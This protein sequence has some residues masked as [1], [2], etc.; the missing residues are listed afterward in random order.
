MLKIDQI[1]Q[2]STRTYHF[3]TIDFKFQNTGTAAAFLWKF[4]VEVL[5]AEIDTMPVLGFDIG[6]KNKVL[7]ML[8]VNNGWGTAHDCQ[9]RISESILNQLYADSM[10]QYTGTIQSGEQKRILFFE[11]DLAN[12]GRFTTISKELLAIKDK[13]SW[14]SQL[15]EFT[16]ISENLV[17]RFPHRDATRE[18]IRGIRLGKAS[19]IW[20]FKDDKNIR[21]TGNTEIPY[22]MKESATAREF[23]LTEKGFYEFH[24]PLA[25]IVDS[26]TT[27]CT[28]I[29]PAKGSHELTYPISR[30]VPSGDV[31]RFHIMV[32][33][34]MSCHLSL[35][36]KFFIDQT[37]IVESEVFDINIW[38][39]RN[40]QWHSKYKDGEVLSRSS[41]DNRG[42]KKSQESTDDD[43]YDFDKKR[44][45]E[46]FTQHKEALAAYE[47]EIFYNQG[48]ALHDLKHYEAALTAY[49]Q[50]IQLNPRKSKLHFCR[51][52][53]LYA[54]KRRDEA[55]FAYKDAI[56]LGLSSQDPIINKFPYYERILVADLAIDK[57]PEDADSHANRGYALYKL[58]DY[59]AALIAYEQAIQLN[60]NHS[61]AFY[62]KGRILKRLGRPE[63][64][65]LAYEKS[66]QLKATK[67]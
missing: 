3:P 13:D 30:K 15:E 67:N 4:V 53:A 56:K 27:Y 26:D 24:H 5:H 45:I 50:A 34:P 2:S 59:E 32:G 64:A 33:A 22:Y 17:D 36:F 63:E 10:C 8:A 20:A 35:R 57:N 46:L 40:S 54:V 49:E 23:F 7:Y 60:P 65:Q 6:V 31:E 18:I 19:A 39:P 21:H 16:E 14:R 42:S 47:A 48:L 9:V 38:N 51:A 1:D 25:G 44:G 52:V 43:I 62:M 58:E 12:Q 29:D 41:S 37:T 55:T 66:R 28:I 11:H 61:E